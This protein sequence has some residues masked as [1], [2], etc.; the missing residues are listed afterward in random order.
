MI[1]RVYAMWNRSK[2]ILYFLLILYVPQVITSFVLTGVLDNP[3]TSMLVTPQQTANF[4][5]CYLS[6]I[7]NKLI[8]T[9]HLYFETL[10]CILSGAILILAVFQTLKQSFNMYK[11]TKQ[12][13]PNRYMQQFVT[14]GV[15]Y[16]LVYVFP[17]SI[18]L[19]YHCAPLTFKC[20]EN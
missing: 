4:T 14:D 20:H 8:V 9:T 10:R 17:F 7:N 11:A 3:G 15:L 2:R 1:L 12:W 6:F 13:Q 16:F 18:S 5:W 19:Y